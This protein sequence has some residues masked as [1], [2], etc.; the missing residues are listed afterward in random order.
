M[1]AG[2]ENRGEGKMKP[3]SV[4]INPMQ[5]EEKFAVET[6]PIPNAAQDVQQ[7]FPISTERDRRIKTAAFVVLISM[8]LN[9]GYQYWFNW[10]IFWGPDVFLSRGIDDNYHNNLWDYLT[11]SE[12][13]FEGG[14]GLVEML[15]F[16]FR[17]EIWGDVANLVG[18]LF[19]LFMM[20][21]LMPFVFVG[22]LVFCWINREKDDMFFRKVT[23]F[24]GGYF[25]IMA[26][27]LVYIKMEFSADYWEF[28]LFFD[29]F[30]FW[31]A[32]FAG[33]ILDPKA[34]KLPER[35]FSGNET[36][37][38]SEEAIKPAMLVLFYFPVVY[39]LVVLNSVMD[40]GDDD[41]L[42]LGIMLP[43]VGFVVGIIRYG[44]EFLK[45]FGLHLLFSIG[46]GFIGY[47]LAIIRFFGDLDDGPPI[48]FLLM[49]SLI[50]TIRYHSKN[51]HR[52][53]I[54]AMYAIPLTFW[55]IIFGILIGWFQVDG[56]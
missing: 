11:H 30:G 53:A 10:T 28:N 15:N 16:F 32:G 39:Y 2:E 23:L 1:D 31:L 33:L 43:I 24:Y 56:W 46:Y 36:T 45:G 41:A 12:F 18:P 38:V 4:V 7:A 14:I 8:F 35:V 37:I 50:L 54:G 48:S 29:C 17:F 3:A 27:Q 5:T 42:F 25:L 13:S 20:R 34:I 52:R 26:V 21:E 9:W 6:Q 55:I 47:F 40:G 49:I 22:T 44:L 19:V 51:K